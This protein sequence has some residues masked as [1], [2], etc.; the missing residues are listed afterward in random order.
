M[1]KNDI[2]V[3]PAHQSNF[4]S[5]LSLG[6]IFGASSLFLLGTKKGRQYVK[7]LVNT[8]ENLDEVGEGI[9]EELKE[10]V[11]ELQTSVHKSNAVDNIETVI[12]KIRSVL[13]EKS[14]HK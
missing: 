7:N 8:M 4:W 1:T 9:I 14:S 10:H 6:V 5:G 2:R 3:H 12:E 11:D 13:P